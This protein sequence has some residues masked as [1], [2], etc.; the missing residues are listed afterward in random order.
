[1]FT[2]ISNAEG[3]IHIWKQF[4]FETEEDLIKELKDS[5]NFEKISPKL[6]DHW[7]IYDKQKSPIDSMT[8]INEIIK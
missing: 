3:I 1:M 7:M 5:I 8:S 6:F 4:E 2:L